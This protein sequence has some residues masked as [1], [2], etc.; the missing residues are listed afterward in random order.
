MSLLY[1]FRPQK[2]SY[3]R[4]ITARLGG[5]GITANEVT[6]LGLCLALVS[7][8][9]A[10]R[11]NLY[12][13]IVCFAASAV[14]DVHDGSLARAS[15]KRTE[16]GLYFD[17]LAD[18]FSE[19]FFVI[20]AVL[21][22][23]VPASAFIVIGGA[24]TLLLARAYGHAQKWG[25]TPTAFGRPERLTLLIAGILCPT[26]VNTLLFIAAGLCC[27]FSSAQ[28]LVHGNSVQGDQCR[29]GV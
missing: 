10:Y 16:F 15:N 27:V 9:L 1:R 6:A 21:G 19:L 22:A 23:N 20:G 29:G 5:A 4:S 3:L 11:G 18:R 7:G 17:G 28:I 25:A 2:D 14:C 8:L 13:G 12:L 26:P 24:F